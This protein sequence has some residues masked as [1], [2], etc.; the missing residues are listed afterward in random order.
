MITDTI[1][2]TR[3]QARQRGMSTIEAL[4]AAAVLA[5]GM[6][7]LARLHVD[8]RA[9]A[10][11]ARERSEAVRLAQ[12]DLEQ[13]RAFATFAAWSAIADAEP[14]DVT[15]T[16]STTRYLRERIVQTDDDSGL[17]SVQ[18]ILRWTDRHGAAQQ[19]RLQTRIVGVD[20]VLS[21]ALALPRPDL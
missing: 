4:A 9:N 3:R 10:E 12:Q 8:L 2:R 17:K 1:A 7:G 14:A 13:L 11:A 19:L 21:G 5:L 15:P 6:I 18:V 16:G 20:P